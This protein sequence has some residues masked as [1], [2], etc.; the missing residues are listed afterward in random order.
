[1][2]IE[3]LVSVSQDKGTGFVII[4]VK[5]IS[6]YFAKDFLDLIITE[7]NSFLRNKELEESSQALDYLKS[8]LAE[9]SL[10][11]LKESINTL[12]E[13]QLEI[14]MLAKINE[15]YI[16]VEIDPPYIPEKSLSNSKT[17]IVIFSTLLGGL[18]GCIVALIKEY[19][20]RQETSDTL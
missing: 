17:L 5:H 4:S 14:Q 13:S 15:D 2:Y 19:L 18:L 6:P 9:I 20:T 7:A 16:L 8:Q 11:E 1:V 12:I 3:D 10:V